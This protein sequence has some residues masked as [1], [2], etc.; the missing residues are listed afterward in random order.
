MCAQQRLKSALVSAQTDPLMSSLCAQWVAK[1]PR[2]LHVDSEDWSDQADRSLHWAH[3]SFCWFC[4]AAAQLSSNTHHICFTVYRI[5]SNNVLC[6]RYTMFGM[7]NPLGNLII[8]QQISWCVYKWVQDWSTSTPT[9]IKI[10]KKDWMYPSAVKMPYEDN[11]HTKIS[12]PRT[13]KFHPFCHLYKTNKFWKV[14][15]DI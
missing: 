4:Y 5:S 12:I 9:S 7:P 14:E 2:F 13:W 8:L 15:P 3:R 11:A 1:D 6:I 10:K